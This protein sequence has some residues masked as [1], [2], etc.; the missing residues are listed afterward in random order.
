MFSCEHWK[1]CGYKGG[2]S[3]ICDHQVRQ[4]MLR[5]MSYWER[6]SFTILGAA[7]CHGGSHCLSCK[8]TAVLM[9]TT[10]TAPPGALQGTR[11][12][13]LPAPAQHIT[14]DNTWGK[15]LRFAYRKNGGRN[16]Y[17]LIIVKYFLWHFSIFLSKH[18]PEKNGWE[19]VSEIFS[20]VF[21]LT[22]VVFILIFPVQ[23]KTYCYRNKVLLVLF[24][25]LQ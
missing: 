2:A 18:D 13:P 3:W 16:K 10:G 12:S 22:N 11:L 8:A 17:F 1:C 25:L 21:S 9:E 14:V 20:Y 5:V 24:C 19:A 6:R 23:N 7:L 15:L 4:V